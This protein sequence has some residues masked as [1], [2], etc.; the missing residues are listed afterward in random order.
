MKILKTNF[1]K[2]AFNRMQ[3]LLLALA[4]L[5][6]FSLSSCEDDE[7]Q[8]AGSESTL[9]D[10]YP[11]SGK[12]ETMLTLNGENIG[13]SRKNVHVWINDKEVDVINVT[14]TKINV[15][16]PAKVGSGTIKV[17][18]GDKEFTYPA[19][20]E[21]IADYIVT[22]YAGNGT[23]GYVD[24]PAESANFHNLTWLACDPKDGVVYTLET[25]FATTPQRVRRI[26]NGVVETVVNFKDAKHTVKL[27]NPRTIEFSSTG[28]TIFVSNDNGNNISANPHAVAILTRNEDF[29]EIKEYVRSDKAGSP[30]LNYAGV[31]PANGK[32]VYYS[33]LG[34][35]YTWNNETKQ[36]TELADVLPVYKIVHSGVGGSY[37]SLRFSPDGKK[38]YVISRNDYQGILSADYNMETNT[39][40]SSFKRF[41][42]TGK[43]GSNDGL[44]V[45]AGMDF[46]SQGVFG[47]DGNIYLVERNNQCVRRVTPTGEVTLFAGTPGAGYADG[48]ASVA[49]FTNPLGFAIDKHGN[50]FVAENVGNRIRKISI[51]E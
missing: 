4:M 44:G 5:A 33:W 28:D 47:S 2:K 17:K 1:M 40:D 14:Q 20:F 23:Q 34:K 3:I 10:F 21:Y 29:K 37:A 50:M 8:Q 27:N 48:E 18:I 41:A 36:A 15:R 24:G 45:E 7:E 13:A 9:T 25:D 32:L 30:H 46:P 19:Q 6:S 12:K 42:G 49:K 39:L 31:N 38:L 35:I 11:T 22:T 43:W 51:E 26:K 16:V